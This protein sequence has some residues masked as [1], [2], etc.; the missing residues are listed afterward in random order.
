MSI[1]FPVGDDLD[2]TNP[3]LTPEEL[4]KLQKEIMERNAF[5][6]ETARESW[7]WGAEIP[8]ELKKYVQAGSILTPSLVEDIISKAGFG[9]P[10]FSGNAPKDFNASTFGNTQINLFPDPTFNQTL[11]PRPG[12]GPD[13]ILRWA[14][15]SIGAMTVIRVRID[16]VLR[17]ANYSDQSW[18]PGWRIT[19]RDSQKYPTKDDK[20]AIKQAID[21]LENGGLYKSVIERDENQSMD[22]PRFLAAIVQDSLIYD[23]IAIL[24]KVKDGKVTAFTP[25][26]AASILI[27][28]PEGY[29]FDKSKFAVEID[30]SGQV[31]QSF[32]R[33]Q[34]IWYVRN[35]GNY[36]TTR[37]YGQSEVE[38]GIKILQ[39]FQ[40]AFDMNANTFANNSMPNGMM[41]ITGVVGI[42]RDTLNFLK[43][44]WNNAVRGVS[45]RWGVPVMALD[46][47]KAK[48]DLIKFNDIK[49]LDHVYEHHMNMTFALICALY[50]MPVARLGMKIS[51]QGPNAKDPMNKD[52]EEQE[53]IGRIVLLQ[54]LE[55]L[56]DNYLI[57]RNWPNLKFSWTAMSSVEGDRE[58]Q[59]RNLA[60]TYRE[61]RIALDMKPVS[62]FLPPDA[63]E[64]L[65]TLAQL[66]DMT[67]NDPGKGGIAQSL[68]SAY[69]TGKM[70]AEKENAIFHAPKDLAEARDKGA[71]PA[72][73]RKA[74]EQK[75]ER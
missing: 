51:G 12:L 59:E 57:K 49:G 15:G 23:N 72:G 62:E 71:P 14:I 31:L 48:V 55:N 11:W 63:P 29:E 41:V 45:K 17:H 1:I 13:A 46:S 53:D 33:D 2:L 61:Q 52:R 67:P 36:Q 25:F 26:N 69:L 4:V 16:D 3:D 8:E 38:L 10:L 74:S 43:R 7:T 21:F 9:T 44:V 22:F 30:P 73:R 32:T 37:Y 56:I 47:E 64:E 20:E 35:P 42:S 54:H 75:D 70:N 27:A 60:Q 18:K 28:K 68:F 5:L 66:L 58:Y 34:L 19:M 50:R 24:T 6:Q 39:S 40:N 65:K